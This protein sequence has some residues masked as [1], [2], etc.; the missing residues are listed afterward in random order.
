MKSKIFPLIAVLAVSLTSCN[1]FNIAK[2]DKSEVNVYNLDK[3]SDGDDISKGYDLTVNAL[4]KETEPLIPYLTLKDYASLYES[5]FAEGVVSKYSKSA[6]GATWMVYRDDEL[7]F[8]S[9]ISFATKT[10]TIG[11]SL[12]ATFKDDDSPKD[13]RALTYGANTT[14]DGKYLSGLGY[15]YYSF[16]DLA[17]KYCSY[18][19]NYYI[20]LGFLDMTFSGDSGIYFY[21]NYER[22][23][24]S[25]EVDTIEGREY[26]A[27]G[28]KTSTLEEM[29]ESINGM[30]DMPLYL[31]KYNAN[32]FFYFL[33]NFYGLKEE[34][35]VSSAIAY[36]KKLGVYNA[37][38]S[39]DASKRVQAIA[40][41]MSYLDD[42][43]TALIS[44]SFAWGETS[45]NRWKYGDGC[46]K[47]S[48]LNSQLSNK[49]LNA[50]KDKGMATPGA[51]GASVLYSDNGKTAMYAFDSFTFGKSSQVFYKDGTI[52]ED[53][54]LYDTFLDLIR[55]FNEIKD[56]G[57]VENVVLDISL[58]G[59]GTVGVMMKLLSL[60]SSSDSSTIY[61]YESPTTQLAWANTSIDINGDDQTTADD[62]FGDDFN[63]YI[64]TSDCSFSAANAFACYASYEGIAKVIGQKSGGGECAVGIHY[65]PNGEYLYHSSNLHLGYYDDRDDK[66]IGFESGAT[67]SL[68]IENLDNFYNIEYLNQQLSSLN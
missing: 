34:K 45:F 53:A 22:I 29:A 47:R 59:G 67:T 20:S 36:C 54:Y 43:H 32:L 30:G 21:Y 35:G 5:H 63:F 48:Q 50:Y 9:D 18:N 10:V 6:S 61:Y 2:Y 62:Y 65:L 11:G 1:I 12:S 28:K 52:Q 14:Y 4:F 39:A 37:L 51:T 44:G 56:K 60:I 58:N 23:V 7:Y 40:D 31:R 68:T 19:N 26:K 17:I 55:V 66:F 42:N 3:I 41:A 38:M 16:S 24:S 57:G 27:D 13:T 25:E 8:V 49:R 15:A 64:L 33:D 46:K